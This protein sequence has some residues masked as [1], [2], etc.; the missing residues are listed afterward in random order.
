MYLSLDGSATLYVNASIAALNALRGT[1]FDAR[2][3]AQVD[4]DAVRAYFDSP[5]THVTRVNLSRR[6]NRRFVHVRMDVDN[7]NRLEEAA[8]FKWS[9]YR[10]GRDGNLFVYQQ[11]VGAAAGKEAGAT[12]WTGH[13]IVAFRLHLPSKI[14]YQNT[15]GPQRRGNI[16]VW[17]QPLTDRLRGVPLTLDARMQTQS[18]LYRTLFLFGATMLA[19]ALSFVALI[20]WILR[21]GRM[22]SAPPGQDQPA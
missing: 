12:G 4:I 6:S 1:T 9:E 17:E 13:E 11:T 16:L 7:V 3:N 18:I 2:P 15:G 5:V 19:V 14:E 20:W 8:P 22:R 21:K 10:F